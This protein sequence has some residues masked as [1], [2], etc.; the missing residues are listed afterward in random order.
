VIDTMAVNVMSHTL[1]QASSR[2]PRFYPSPLVIRAAVP[3]DTIYGY[4]IK[5]H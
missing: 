2:G 3:E 1:I 4:I 5:K